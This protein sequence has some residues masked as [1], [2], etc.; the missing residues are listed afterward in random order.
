MDLYLFFHP[1]SQASSSEGRENEEAKRFYLLRFKHWYL[2]KQFRS[3]T[4]TS[5]SVNLW[6][7]I[8]FIPF[9]F[10]LK[11]NNTTI[12]FLYWVIFISTQ[13]FIIFYLLWNTLNQQYF[14]YFYVGAYV[15]VCLGN[16][17]EIN[18]Q[19]KYTTNNNHPGMLLKY[20]AVLL[21]QPF[22]PG[23]IF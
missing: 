8:L 6:W 11:S 22:V 19:Q 21:T 5:L 1:Q 7:Q 10:I 18:Q 23:T 13:L 15:V 17:F 9:T 4:F 12:F 2:L 14:Y 20:F 3:F 16:I